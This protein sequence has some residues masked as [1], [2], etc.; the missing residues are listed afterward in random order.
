MCVFEFTD[1]TQLLSVY[2]G[3]RKSESLRAEKVCSLKAGLNDNNVCF[4]NYVCVIIKSIKCFPVSLI[5]ITFECRFVVCPLRPWRDNSQSELW[6]SGHLSILSRANRRKQKDYEDEEKQCYPIK[7]LI[8]SSLQIC[9]N[10]VSVLHHL[11]ECQRLQSGAWG[12]LSS[13]ES[14]LCCT[15][16]SQQ[17][18]EVFSVNLKV[19]LLSLLSFFVF[20]KNVFHLGESIYKVHLNLVLHREM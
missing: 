17:V 18:L 7:P 4:K 2:V 14:L 16:S 15:V 11:G 1:S 10:Q 6:H 3:S 5:L 19:N 13:P 20:W 12:L 8:H 9:G